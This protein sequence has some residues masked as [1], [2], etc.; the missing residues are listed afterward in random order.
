MQRCARESIALTL[1]TV[2]DMKFSPEKYR[3]ATV[4]RAVS[5]G[6]TGSAGR[7]VPR[8]GS[9]VK[10]Y[11]SSTTVKGICSPRTRKQCSS[12]LHIWSKNCNKYSCARINRHSKNF[13]NPQVAKV[14][15]TA[16]PAL[17]TTSRNWAQ[18][19]SRHR[20]AIVTAS[21][22]QSTQSPISAQIP[23]NS[24]KQTRF[25]PLK[26][27][28]KGV[29]FSPAGAHTCMP[30]HYT[31]AHLCAPVHCIGALLSAPVHHTGAHNCAPIKL[32]GTHLCAPV[33]L[34]GAPLGHALN[35]LSRTPMCV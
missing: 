22:L 11:T 15:R 9:P 27:C 10:K 32:T 5:L 30:V 7:G 35:F 13:S 3:S 12:G 16:S 24:I 17:A 34:T 8:K 23:I 1:T 33:Q 25:L 21:N 18:S 14:A 6:S 29:V 19:R 26:T 4:T 28:L 20:T 31:G 2:L